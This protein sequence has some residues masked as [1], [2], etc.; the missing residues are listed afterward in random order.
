M[1]HSN[2][3]SGQSVQLSCH[4]GSVGLGCMNIS[5]DPS[6]FRAADGYFS[7]IPRSPPP[8]IPV[9]SYKINY[10][11]ASRFPFCLWRPWDCVNLGRVSA[12]V[13]HLMHTSHKPMLAVIQP[14]VFYFIP[15]GTP[16]PPLVRAQTPSPGK[17]SKWF[18]L[19]SPGLLHT[20][21][22]AV[23]RVPCICRLT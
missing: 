22:H 19:W 23:Y 16:A 11:S 14:S 7:S 15:S 9:R 17:Q 6:T 2:T 21:Q 18:N 8:C 13:N 5:S 3:G 10:G 1:A 12:C 20:T 4:P